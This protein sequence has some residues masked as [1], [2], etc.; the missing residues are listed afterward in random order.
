MR[1][2]ATA[3]VTIAC[4]PFII[5][6]MIMAQIPGVKKFPLWIWKTFYDRKEDMDVRLF[7]LLF[8]TFG[9]TIVPVLMVFVIK[10]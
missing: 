5:F 7:L 1:E 10:L 8:F 6:L 4:L 2:A 9:F 3:L